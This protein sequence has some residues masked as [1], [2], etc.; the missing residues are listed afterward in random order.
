MIFLKFAFSL[1]LVFIYHRYTGEFSLPQIASGLSVQSALNGS[2]H[3]LLVSDGVSGIKYRPEVGAKCGW[4][5]TAVHG[6]Q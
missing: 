3:H 4:H 1:L 5:M 6:D 2:S